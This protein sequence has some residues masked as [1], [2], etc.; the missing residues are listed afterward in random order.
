MADANATVSRFV[1]VERAETAWLWWWGQRMVIDP[2]LFT[3]PVTPARWKSVQGDPG[4]I[5]TYTEGARFWLWPGGYY[6][7]TDPGYVHTAQVLA[8][9]RT[10]LQNQVNQDG[11][12]PYANCP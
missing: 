1:R 11:P 8:T 6:P 4:A 7:R 2:S 10:A 9:Y 12:P 5:L 3:T